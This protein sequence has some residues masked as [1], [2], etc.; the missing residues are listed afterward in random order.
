[1]AAKLF[2]RA[3]TNFSFRRFKYNGFEL[4]TRLNTYKMIGKRNINCK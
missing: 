1:M 3:Y 2:S 4:Q